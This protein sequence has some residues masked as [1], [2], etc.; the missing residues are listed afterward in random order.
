M[1]VKQEQS[2]TEEARLCLDAAVGVVSLFSVP[3]TGPLWLLSSDAR[4][5]PLFSEAWDVYTGHIEVL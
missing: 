1:T 3:Y 2:V 4:E 5:M